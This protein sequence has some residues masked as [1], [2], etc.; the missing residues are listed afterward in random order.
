[1]GYA[2]CEESAQA[3]QANASPT[4]RAAGSADLLS[5]LAV[6]YYGGDLRKTQERSMTARFGRRL[7]RLEARG[8]LRTL[9]PGKVRAFATLGVVIAAGDLLGPARAYAGQAK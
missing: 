9:W 6:F 1:M 5:E 3:Q 8:S 7:F 4:T 2:C